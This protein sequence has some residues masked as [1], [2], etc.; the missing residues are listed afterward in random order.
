M[1]QNTEKPDKQPRSHIE[2]EEVQQ[3][4]D[5]ETSETEHSQGSVPIVIK[6]Q[7]KKTEKVLNASV[8]SNNLE[9]DVQQRTDEVETSLSPY[10]LPKN[11]LKKRTCAVACCKRPFPE[12]TTFFSFPK[13]ENI[14]KAWLLAC[15]RKDFVNL[16]NAV[17]CS[18]HFSDDCF[19]RDLRSELLYKVIKR[20]LKDDSIPSLGLLPSMSIS[21]NISEREKRSEARKN[22]S[23]VENLITESVIDEP[24]L[25]ES[26]LPDLGNFEMSAE[27]LEI[28]RLKKELFESKNEIE[29]LRKE[30]NALKSTKGKLKMKVYSLQGKLGRVKKKEKKLSNKSK[31]EVAKNVLKKS[32]WSKQQISYFIDNKKRINWEPEDFV[33]GLTIRA[34]SSRSYKFLRRK[35]LL[36]LPGISTLK[37]HVQ[38]FTCPPGI[39]KNILQVILKQCDSLNMCLVLKIHPI[40]VVLAFDEMSI[41]RTM[42]YDQAEQKVYGPHKQAQVALVHGMFKNFIQ[43]VYYDFDQAM[44]KPILFNIIEETEKV[45]LQVEAIVSDMGPSNQGLWKALD[46]NCTW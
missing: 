37:K 26:D 33:L 12:N 25:D 9:S 39:Q 14:R 5:N 43:P 10:C 46:A 27:D 32:S 18:Q 8:Q 20:K 29:K 1:S 23:L 24:T 45:G 21:S 13:K 4:H 34:L 2:P 7:K 36:P 15:K 35:K 42:Q 6:F 16:K 22:K 31:L 40:P 11:T 28:E 17:I 41:L 19:E 38:H 30:N 3:K 44:T